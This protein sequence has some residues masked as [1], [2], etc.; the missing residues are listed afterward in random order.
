MVPKVSRDCRVAAA[1]AGIQI[2]WIMCIALIP[3]KRT[4][5]TPAVP[6]PLANATIVSSEVLSVVY[7]IHIC[8]FS[9][10]KT[11]LTVAKAKIRMLSLFH[12]F[13]NKT[14]D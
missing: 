2:V 13:R 8:C 10:V 1:R 6:R 4:T 12:V 14:M 3:L 5:A 9:L 7:P 11:M